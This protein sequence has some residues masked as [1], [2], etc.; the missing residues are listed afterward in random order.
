[1]PEPQWSASNHLLERKSPS[2]TKCILILSISV[3]RVALKNKEITCF[4][5]VRYVYNEVKDI[6]ESNTTT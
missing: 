3:N 1:M 6:F 4:L 5:S 2:S